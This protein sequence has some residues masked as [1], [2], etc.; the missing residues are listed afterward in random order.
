MTSASCRCN[1]RFTCGDCIRN[2]KPYYGP[3]AGPLQGRTA[4]EAAK[5]AA[6]ERRPETER[7]E[8]PE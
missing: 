7:A 3:M 8:R 4:A 5:D 1:P 6:K 2:A